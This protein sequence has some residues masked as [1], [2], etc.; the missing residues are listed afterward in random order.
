VRDRA[1]DASWI[2]RVLPSSNVI[3]RSWQLGPHASK[4]MHWSATWPN[5]LMVALPHE[6][7]PVSPP[8]STNVA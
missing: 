3:V 7:I 8:I 1:D 4:T 2:T 5:P 6:P